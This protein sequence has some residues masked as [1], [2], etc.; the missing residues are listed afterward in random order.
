[1]R[2]VVPAFCLALGLVGCASQPTPKPTPAAPVEVQQGPLDEDDLATNDPAATTRALTTALQAGHD[3]AQVYLTQRSPAFRQ[4]VTTLAV[5][6]ANPKALSPAARQTAI[7]R[8]SAQK[9]VWEQTEKA[10]SVQVSALMQAGLQ[11]ASRCGNEAHGAALSPDCQTLKAAMNTWGKDREQVH[12]V[13]VEDYL[14]WVLARGPADAA[15]PTQ[16]P[17]ITAA[18]LT[19]DE[20]ATQCKILDFRQPPAGSAL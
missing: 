18:N 12:T 19:E 5:T 6:L 8:V 16:V 13:M 17:L 7:Q 20:G 14:L 15:D 9:T 3:R 10:T 1:M 11:E 4:E 2:R